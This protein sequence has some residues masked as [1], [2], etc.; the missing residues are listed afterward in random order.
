MIYLA[1]REGSFAGGGQV[2]DRTLGHAAEPAKSVAYSAGNALEGA[3]KSLKDTAS[4][5]QTP[6]ETTNAAP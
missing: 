3:G 4:S 2:V 6:A 1:V 5:D